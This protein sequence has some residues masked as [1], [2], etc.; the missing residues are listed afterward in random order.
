MQYLIRKYYMFIHFYEII[1]LGRIILMC[2]QPPPA[3]PANYN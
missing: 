2:I 3:G 1:T